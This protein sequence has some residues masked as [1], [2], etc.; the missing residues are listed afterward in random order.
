LPFADV[1]LE[2]FDFFGGH[3]GHE[4]ER[5]RLNKLDN[6]AEIAKLVSVTFLFETEVLF[7]PSLG[8]SCDFA[9]NLGLFL[10]AIDNL[11]DLFSV[12]V[13][14]EL[15]Q[16][17]HAEF[18]VGVVNGFHSHALELLPVAGHHELGVEL[19]D[20]R[21]HSVHVLNAIVKSNEAAPLRDDL[22]LGNL[23]VA[24]LRLHILN[25]GCKQISVDL[26]PEG[27][28]PRVELV[29]DKSNQ[30]P[31]LLKGDKLGLAVL[32]LFVGG[33]LQIEESFQVVKLFS[34]FLKSAS[35]IVE[36]SNLFVRVVDDFGRAF[37]DVVR[38]SVL[39]LDSELL[40]D[41]AEAS[42]TSLNVLRLIVLEGQDGLFDGAECFL[43][44]VLEL[45]LASFKSDE[46]VLLHLDLMLLHEHDSLLHGVN[47]RNSFVLD[48]LDITQVSH[49]GH[50]LVTLGGG[51]VRLGHDFDT[52]RNVSDE[53]LDVL[54]LHRGV[55]EEEVGVCI[56]PQ[57]NC[58][59]ELLDKGERVNAE[60][61]NI[62]GLLHLAD[63]L[64]DTG[65]V[66]DLIVE[67]FEAGEAGGHIFEDL[68]AHPCEAINLLFDALVVF[69]RASAG[70]L[71]LLS[72]ELFKAGA[73]VKELLE[74]IL[75]LLFP[76][77]LL[78]V[79]LV[80]EG[81]GGILDLVET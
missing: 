44:D 8:D 26:V 18:G 49:D 58:L 5:L 69:V 40:H 23:G 13:E 16:V 7:V 32:E 71:L 81:S 36:F 53:L 21:Q 65:Q 73:G 68:G 46:E 28:L 55:V 17:L 27:L 43:G 62:N 75:E 30:I 20:K 56:N 25:E 33:T 66:L 74:G 6:G 1:L 64:L 37:S 24:L 79:V 38:Q 60:P 52:F 10:S 39:E 15:D 34:L 42:Q 31:H 2:L 50:E 22:V 47:L 14:V 45:G 57:R 80:D 77:E 3:H 29:V 48:H 19:G 61:A 70:E 41:D 54:D 72:E 9:F 63:L 76:Q 11:S 51:L 78:V 35:L 4:L 67:D 12:L 59:L